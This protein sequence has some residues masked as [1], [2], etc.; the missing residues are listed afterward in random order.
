MDSITLLRQQ[1]RDTHGLLEETM[2]DVSPEQTH[3]LPP[4]TAN[5][6]GATYAHAIITEDMFING[7]LK[8]T[9]P[10]SALPEWAGQTGI[11]EPMPRPGPEWENYGPWA[12]RVQVDLAALRQYAQAVYASSDQYL[13]SLTP[14]DLDRSIDMGQ[15]ELEQHT[16]AWVLS[17]FVIVHAA[18]ICGEISCLKGLQGARGYPF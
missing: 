7:I 5:P 2:A 1:L 8:G 3:W 12:H 17:M 6:L 11:S 14:E 16:L 9:A 10:M 18:N 15:G 4:G 13:A